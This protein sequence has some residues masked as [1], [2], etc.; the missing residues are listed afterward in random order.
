MT[1][2]LATVVGARPQLIKASALSD[3]IERRNDVEEV[4]IHTGQHFDHNMSGVFF[5]ELG[6]K[7]PDRH[8][9][10]SGGRHGEMTSRMLVALELAFE[11]VK[12]DVVLVYGD[13]NS[14]LAAALAA[15]KLGIPIAHVEAGLRSYNRAMP[16][17]INRVLTDHMSSWLFT[18]TTEATTNLETEGIGPESVHQVGD[19]MLDVALYNSSRA[20][21]RFE[22]FAD[23]FGLERG[24][25]VLVTIHRAENTDDDARFR[26]IV[27]GLV[28]AAGEVPI[29]WPVHPRAA[30]ALERIGRSQESSGMTYLPPQG[31]LDMMALERA[32]ACLSLIHI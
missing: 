21:E 32:A 17:E 15:S 18:P 27:D 5:D 16:E 1:P 13:T 11:E 6:M 28:L 7:P 23:A 30:A 31:Y 2:I 22:V 19:V 3:V 10:I 9:G 20:D 24:S 26:A 29:V 8:L 25:Y 14:T 12:P 4:L